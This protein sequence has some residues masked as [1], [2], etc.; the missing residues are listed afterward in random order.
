MATNQGLQNPF[1]NSGAMSI[2]FCRQTLIAKNFGFET[3]E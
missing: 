2:A 3:V 1:F